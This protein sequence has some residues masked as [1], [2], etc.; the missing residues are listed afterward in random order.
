LHRENPFGS[1]NS[2]P[3]LIIP[4]AGQALPKFNVTVDL[5]REQ[6]IE[7]ARA[8]V[9]DPDIR[10][11]LEEEIEKDCDWLRGFLFAAQV[12]SKA[13]SIYDN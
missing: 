7:A 12:C 5:I 2:F 3:S 11:E 10:G 9:R 8:S 13:I 4:K 6:H 1:Q